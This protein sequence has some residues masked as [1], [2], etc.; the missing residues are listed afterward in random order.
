MLKASRW[1]RLAKGQTKERRK[2]ESGAGGQWRGRKRGDR[3]GERSFRVAVRATE[4]LQEFGNQWTLLYPP[5]LLFSPPSPSMWGKPPGVSAMRFPW[6]LTCGP[7]T[8]LCNVLR[9]YYSV[10]CG[11]FM[12]N[13]IIF[14]RSQN[15]ILGESRGIQIKGCN[16]RAALAVGGWCWSV[17]WWWHSGYDFQECHQTFGPEWNMLD[18]TIGWIAMTFCTTFCDGTYFVFSAILHVSKC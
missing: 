10:F 6:A 14:C 17:S 8:L 7:L 9:C 11:I 16:R 5:P 2:L 12:E 4:A 3:R 1:V 18:S 13:K 15:N